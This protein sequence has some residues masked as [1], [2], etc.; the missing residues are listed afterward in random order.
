MN[1]RGLHSR[2]MDRCRPASGPRASGLRALAPALALLAI[3]LNFLQPLAH[4]ALMRE[5]SPQVLWTAF[6]NSMDATSPADSPGPVPVAKQAHEC[7]LGLAHSPSLL[8][9]ATSFIAVPPVSLAAAPLPRFEPAPA[10]AIR[11]GP[12]SPRGPPSFV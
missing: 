7:C 9:P 1:V 10:I 4:A 8:A 6:C 11:D 12:A 2:A 3:T 5:G